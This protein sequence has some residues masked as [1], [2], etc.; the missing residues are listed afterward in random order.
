MPNCHHLHNRHSC[1]LRLPTTPLILTTTT[2][3]V[4]PFCSNFHIST[5]ASICLAATTSHGGDMR[6]TETTAPAPALNLLFTKYDTCISSPL[7]SS[8][9][10]SSEN[11]ARDGWRCIAFARTIIPP[12]HHHWRIVAGH[13]DGGRCR[14]NTDDNDND[15][16]N[17]DDHDIVGPC[18]CHG[19]DLEGQA[20]TRKD[21][22]HNGVNVQGKCP[23]ILSHHMRGDDA[24][25]PPLRAHLPTYATA[26]ER[27]RARSTSRA[28][29]RQRRRPP[30]RGYFFFSSLCDW[31]QAII[32]RYCQI[33][34]WPLSKNC[35]Q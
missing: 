9:S 27:R 10:S 24:I 28:M 4:S 3:L 33:W 31:P 22:H 12:W 23:I 15:D 18:Y 26:T 34:R 19:I 21:D 25:S 35:I 2:I 32:W 11:N 20:T 29:Q 8:L 7:S 13:N 1:P 30:Q 17:N 16:N 5:F 14:C 6:W